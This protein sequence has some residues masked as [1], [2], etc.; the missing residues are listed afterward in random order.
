LL[1]AQA[2]SSPWQQFLKKLVDL[3][4]HA[5]PQPMS[6]CE[7]ILAPLTEFGRGVRPRVLSVV[8]PQHQHGFSGHR[9]QSFLLTR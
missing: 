5:V 6:N 3:I 1:D 4:A 7:Y 8:L 9:P 2:L